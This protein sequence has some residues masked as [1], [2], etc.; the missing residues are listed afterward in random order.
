MF[1]EVIATQ[2]A[3]GAARLRGELVTVLARLR[4]ELG[5]REQPQAGLRLPELVDLE[6]VV[7]TDV[8]VPGGCR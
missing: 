2:A 4:S 3:H 6:G 8:V 1:R 5:L 7:T